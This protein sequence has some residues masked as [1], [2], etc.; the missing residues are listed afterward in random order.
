M[1][2]KTFLMR[3]GYTVGLLYPLG[4]RTSHNERIVMIISFKWFTWFS[5]YYKQRQCR[6]RSIE[7]Y[8][9][10]DC[11]CAC[12]CVAS[13]LRARTSWNR[14]VMETRLLIAALITRVKRSMRGSNIHCSSWQD[15]HL[16]QWWSITKWK[17]CRTKVFLVF[18]ISFKAPTTFYI[19]PCK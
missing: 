5:V 19:S 15:R 18:V 16:N 7:Y 9:K 12:A 6:R 8:S 2:E 17:T 11:T 4:Y 10:I 13:T 3:C 14:K 1:V